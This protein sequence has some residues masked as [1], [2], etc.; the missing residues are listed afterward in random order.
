MSFP[1]TR[2]ASTPCPPPAGATTPS[3]GAWA[4]AEPASPK[5]MNVIF[6]AALLIG[7][8][9]SHERAGRWVASCRK[10]IGRNAQRIQNVAQPAFRNRHARGHSAGQPQQL[11]KVE[12]AVEPRRD[13]DGIAVDD[14]RHRLSLLSQE[15]KLRLV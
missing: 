3:D 4:D 15:Q 14:D 2:A 7:C 11:E 13:G 12:P 9:S 1:D 8:A 5:T 10:R 6:P